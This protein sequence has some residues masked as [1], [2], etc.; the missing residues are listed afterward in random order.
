MCGNFGSRALIMNSPWHRWLKRA[1]LGLL[2]LVGLAALA[3]ILVNPSAAIMLTLLLL[4]PFFANGHPPPIVAEQFVEARKL[5]APEIS[6]KLT[7]QLLRD[8][9]PG[10]PEE[11]LKSTL[12][13]QGFKPLPP[14]RADCVAPGQ[15]PPFRQT[16]RPCPVGD[17]GWIVAY[18]WAIAVC[19][20]SITVRWSADDERKIAGLNAVFDA[21]CL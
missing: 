2:A 15:T 8:F 10:T 20:Y 11:S 4:Q 17:R 19:G 6:G 3:L 13:G 5:K 16:F 12:L 9:P 18:H 14:P 21:R 7:A 1:V